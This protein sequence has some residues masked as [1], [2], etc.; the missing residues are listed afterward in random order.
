MHLGNLKNCNRIISIFFVLLLSMPQKIIFAKNHKTVKSNFNFLKLKLKQIRI[1][2]LTDETQ[3]LEIEITYP[4]EKLTTQMT[5]SSKSTSI[6][7]IQSAWKNFKNNIYSSDS[8]I[9][10][11][12]LLPPTKN[13]IVINI[14]PTNEL[15]CSTKV[16]YALLIRQGSAPTFPIVADF[17]RSLNVGSPQYLNY[18]NSKQRYLTS[19]PNAITAFDFINYVRILYLKNKNRL[20]EKPKGHKIPK[21]IHQI[22]LGDKSY[23]KNRL[24]DE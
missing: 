8:L 2:N 4:N 1:E 3:N 6:F 23:L 24:F 12:K 17:D 10:N 20:I 11:I 16:E 19:L 21:V 5:V 7:K 13:N 15:K 22:R 18:I 14:I 9:K